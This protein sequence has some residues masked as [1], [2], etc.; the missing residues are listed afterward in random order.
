MLTKMQ[1]RHDEPNNVFVYRGKV[2]TE[3]AAI[4]HLY[5]KTLPSILLVDSRGYVRWHAVGLPT[6]ASLNALK[7]LVNSNQLL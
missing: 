1:L 5:D 7:F 4:F 6:E 2:T 3:L